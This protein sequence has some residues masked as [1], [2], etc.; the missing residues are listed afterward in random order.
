MRHFHFFNIIILSATF[1]MAACNRNSPKD[2]DSFLTNYNKVIIEASSLKK[3]N[4]DSDWEQLD[5]KFS[6]ML[7]ESEPAFREQ[8]SKKETLRFWEDAL[9]YVYVRY[10]LE[11]LKRYAQTDETIIRI[12]A[13]ILKHEIKLN[14]TMKR[15]CKEW[16][17]LYGTDADA[18]SS[19]LKKIFQLPK[20]K[21]LL[22]SPTQESTN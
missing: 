20:K 11:L 3:G 15:L 14:P 13:A 1:L 12:R 17:V 6:I 18:I 8:L 5:R 7:K 2:K 19:D 21:R 22:S 4:K 16:P 10:G 9:G